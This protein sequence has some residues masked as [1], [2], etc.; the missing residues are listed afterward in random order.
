MKELFS[1]ISFKKEEREILDSVSL[2]LDKASSSN[3]V[4]SPRQLHY[5]MIRNN[6][7]NDKDVPFT[8]FSRM[9]RRGLYGGVLCWNAFAYKQSSWNR[10][11]SMIPRTE[12]YVRGAFIGE[13]ADHLYSGMDVT[14]N[15]TAG[16]TWDPLVIHDTS[17]RA[18]YHLTEE[19]TFPIDY[20]TDA[21]D[22]ADHMYNKFCKIIRKMVQVKLARNYFN[23][24]YHGMEW[25]PEGVTNSG[26]SYMTFRRYATSAL[27]IAKGKVDALMPITN[28]GLKRGSK[29]AKDAHQGRLASLPLT[30]LTAML[31][32]APHRSVI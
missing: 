7:I 14:V 32:N 4:Y 25:L 21:F 6:V 13:W 24:A 30:T 2:L 19:R 10:E 15:T 18:Y 3:L 22:T 1:F 29:L 31:Y 28:L 16:L 26:K 9:L 11:K 27:N 8:A 17:W 5:M 12:L 20:I 23:E